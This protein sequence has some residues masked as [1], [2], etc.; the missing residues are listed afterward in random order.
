MY[1]N[2]EKGISKRKRSGNFNLLGAILFG[3]FVVLLIAGEYVLALLSII[4]SLVLLLAGS[5]SS[6]K[7]QS[8]DLTNLVIDKENASNRKC[9]KCNYITNEYDKFCANCGELLKKTCDKCA[10]INPI[11]AKY[12]NNC[13]NKNFVD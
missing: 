1:S 7:S 9:P 5:I 12:C 4:I 6:N 13:G 10:T 8:R 11:D 2:K 3:I